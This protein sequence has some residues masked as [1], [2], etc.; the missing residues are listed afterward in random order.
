M[1]RNCAWHRWGVRASFGDARIAQV[2]C[3]LTLYPVRTINKPK[4]MK[5]RTDL[6]P[7]KHCE[8]LSGESSSNLG[9]LSVRIL[10][11]VPKA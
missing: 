7:E 3:V 11:R 6:W 10:M 1:S 4:E 9:N 2:R 5:P 8:N